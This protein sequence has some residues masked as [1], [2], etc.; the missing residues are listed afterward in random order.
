MVTYDLIINKNAYYYTLYELNEWLIE[1]PVF[2]AEANFDFL[3]TGV[4]EAD[5]FDLF[6]FDS[7]YKRTRAGKSNAKR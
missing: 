4:L 5:S 3:E 6:L 7:T 1:L 2:S